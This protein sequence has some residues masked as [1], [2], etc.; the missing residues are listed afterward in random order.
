MSRGGAFRKRFGVDKII[1]PSTREPG[2]HV[3][4]GHVCKGSPGVCLLTDTCLSAHH[5]VLCSVLVTVSGK[6]ALSLPF[7]LLFTW[8]LVSYCVRDWSNVAINKHNYSLSTFKFLE[9]W[10]AC[11]EERSLKSWGKIQLDL[12][13]MN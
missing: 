3:L 4:L 2:I 9:T 6:T 10:Y 5:R 12:W 1:H 11:Q 7:P 8:F 13:F